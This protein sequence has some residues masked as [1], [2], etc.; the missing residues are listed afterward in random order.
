M[1]QW[2]ILIFLLSFSTVFA[3]TPPSNAAK[4]YRMFWQPMF[5]K[6]ALNYCN[7]TKTQCGGEIATAYCQLMGFHH[8]K[9]F[10]KAPNLG[11]TNF[12][13]GKNMCRGW[14]C[15]GFEWIECAGERS[16]RTIPNSDYRQELFVR[17]KWHKY[18]MS[19]C[20]ANKKQCGK[21][22]AYAFCRWQGYLHAKEISKPKSVPAS[23]EIGTSALC[24][25]EH[26][27]SFEYIVCS[28]D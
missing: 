27:K 23:K 3:S 24:F 5:H 6:Q 2:K 28:R 12:I 10:R 19:W 11:L 8:A 7:E 17:P 15:D 9:R 26:C 20:Y 13:S 1:Y 14:K 4:I 16:Y 25:E 18:S 21:R 22:A